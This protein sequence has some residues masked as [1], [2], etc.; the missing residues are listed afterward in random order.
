MWFG[1]GR[2]GHLGTLPSGTE[3]LISMSVGVFHLPLMVFKAKDASGQPEI[4]IPDLIFALFASSLQI[5][6]PSE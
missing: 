4:Y 1:T 2:M 3:T 6:I 5:K